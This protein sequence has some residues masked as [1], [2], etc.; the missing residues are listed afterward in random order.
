MRGVVDAYNAACETNSKL[1]F[2]ANPNESSQTTAQDETDMNPMPTP[3]VFISYSWSS[4]PHV[5]WVENLANRLQSDGVEVILDRWDLKR[6]HDK[7]AFMERMVTDPEVKKVLAICDSQYAVKADGRQG[8]VGTESQI[9]SPKVYASTQQEK[10]IPIVREFDQGAPCLPTFFKQTIYLDFSD[11]TRFEEMFEELLRDIFDAPAKKKPPLGKPPAHLFTPNAVHVRTAGEFSRLKAAVENHRPNVP[12]YFDQY[13]DRFIDSLEDFRISVD[14]SNR[15]TFDD[16][17]VESIEQFRPYR[18]NFVEC[19][20]HMLKFSPSEAT[21][22]SIIAFLE[23]LIP[24]QSRPERISRWSEDDSDNFRF[25]ATE[26]FLY[27]IAACLRTRQF[28]FAATL[29]ECDYQV[30][31]NLGGSEFYSGGACLLNQYVGTLDTMRN[32]RLNLNK[33]SVAAMILKERAP[34]GSISFREIAQVDFLLAIRGY[35]PSINRYGG[36]YA[37]CLPYVLRDGA[38]ELFSRASSDRGMEPLQTLLRVP[39]RQALMDGFEKLFGGR[40]DVAFDREA[41]YFLSHLL[42]LEQ[43]NQV[44]GRNVGAR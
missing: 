6:G 10:F 27:L 43:L 9:I 18:D 29:I 34:S 11:D 21:E 8:G 37:R 40:R 35:F 2:S 24:F 41:W 14:N 7:Y 23:K 44:S 19:T 17:V 38:M 13:L 5:E 12:A 32:K 16:V 30:A 15:A 42:N 22:S 4:D 1:H 20:L 25:L 39:N 36:W 28:K 33:K 3:K 26:L 31:K